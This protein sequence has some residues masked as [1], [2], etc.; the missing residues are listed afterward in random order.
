MVNDQFTD[1]KIVNNQFM[2]NKLQTQIDF[3]ALVQT[4][5]HLP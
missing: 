3:G 4:I 1:S 5:P 2:E